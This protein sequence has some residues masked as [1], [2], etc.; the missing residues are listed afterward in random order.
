MSHHVP[1]L[2]EE[3]T[4]R[5]LLSPRTVCK[6]RFARSLKQYFALGLNFLSSPIKDEYHE[7]FQIDVRTLHHKI[8]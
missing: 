1:M 4:T 7:R 5:R 2:K 3:P 6:S 8:V